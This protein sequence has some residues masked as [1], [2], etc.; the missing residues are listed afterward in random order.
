ML[1]LPSGCAGLTSGIRKSRTI[2][3]P[4]HVQYLNNRLSPMACL[5]LRGL[6]QA[7]LKLLQALLRNVGVQEVK[8]GV[9]C[10]G[11]PQGGCCLGNIAKAQMNH[12]GM[13][14]QPGILC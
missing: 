5:L 7:L 3:K 11:A 8:V 10:K 9:D 4:A 6:R 1:K 12:A 14:E 2:S 13:K